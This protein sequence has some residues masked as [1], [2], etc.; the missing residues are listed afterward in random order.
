MRPLATQRACRPDRREAGASGEARRPCRCRSSA[1][2][3]SRYISIALGRSRDFNTAATR[4][5]R[6]A[7][8]R[9]RPTIRSGRPLVLPGSS[10]ACSPW[11]AP[12]TTRAGCPRAEVL[13]TVGGVRLFLWPSHPHRM[14]LRPATQSRVMPQADRRPDMN[15]RFPVPFTIPY[16]LA[17]CSGRESPM[18][19]TNENVGLL[20]DTG[21]AY[22][23]D[24]AD[25]VALL[26][27]SSRPSRT[28]RS[29]RPTRWQGRTSLGIAQ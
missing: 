26:E 21:Q 13:V 24:A 17:M 23:G 15:A 18:S 4:A 20:F 9:N 11:P 5:I 28:R 8:R 19:K 6:A 29:R 3:V 16:A 22:F 27:M 1:G 7:H 12:T 14:A 10:S 25:L 2:W